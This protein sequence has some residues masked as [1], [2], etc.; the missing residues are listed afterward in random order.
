MSYLLSNLLRLAVAG[1][2]AGLSCTA[3][4]PSSPS[5]GSMTG[6][7]VD[8]KGKPVQGTVLALVIGQT[9]R[10]QTSSNGSFTFANLRKGTYILCFRPSVPNSKSDS[11]LLVDTCAWQDNT[12]QLIRLAPGQEAS[13]VI[14]RTVHGYALDV[15]INDSSHKLSPSLGGKFAPNDLSIV[16]AAPSGQPRHL[17]IVSEDESGR[18]HQIIIPYGVQHKL[19]LQSSKFDLLHS[20]GKKVD[21]SMPINVNVPSDAS[22]PRFVVSIGDPKDH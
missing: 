22:A 2:V 3:Q 7:A 5:S 21:P 11:Q 6:R 18:S 1:S 12:S 14:V 17:P 15:R 19:Y 10:A 20:D 13:D 9:L 16:I 4:A 8:E